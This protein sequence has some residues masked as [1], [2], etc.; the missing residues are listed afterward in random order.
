MNGYN[1]I[2][3]NEC[4]L[5]LYYIFVDNFICYTL[6][7][8]GYKLHNR[9]V[10][11]MWSI[12]EDALEG[13]S[14]SRGSSNFVDG[15]CN[16]IFSVTRT[17]YLMIYIECLYDNLLGGL[18]S[19]CVFFHDKLG[20]IIVD[21]KPCDNILILSFKALRRVSFGLIPKKNPILASVWESYFLILRN[22]E[23]RRSVPKMPLLPLA[24][25]P[26]FSCE[27]VWVD[28]TWNETYSLLVTLHYLQ[29]VNTFL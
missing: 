15:R 3:F 23:L 14:V 5:F 12:T 26:Y 16:P 1:G 25:D 2:V 29:F 28:S 8:I 11:G 17:K 19:G 9:V 21:V 10:V 7:F 24:K 20:V 22:T 13:C 4:V 27:I 6:Y 18:I